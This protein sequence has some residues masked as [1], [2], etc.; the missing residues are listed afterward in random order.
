M[1]QVIAS[2]SP[3]NRKI[4][5]IRKSVFGV[6]STEGAAVGIFCSC[7]LYSDRKSRVFQALPPQDYAANCPQGCSLEG[8]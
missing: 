8:L 6:K 1:A 5:V 7:N 2:V 4:S 3:E